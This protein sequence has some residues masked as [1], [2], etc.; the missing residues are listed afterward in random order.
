MSTKL[1]YLH[2]PASQ[3]CRSARQFMV[4][5]DIEFEDEVVDI[6]TNINET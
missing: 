4:E 2:H 3:P 1:R 5:N 6:T